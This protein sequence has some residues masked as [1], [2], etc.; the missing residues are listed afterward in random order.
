MASNHPKKQHYVP[1]FY[2]RNFGKGKKHKLYVFDKQNNKVFSA[3]PNNVLYE[4]QFYDFKMKYQNYDCI[5]SIEETLSK[6]ECDTKPILDKM[7]KEDGISFISHQEQII[8]SKFIMAQL[9]RTKNLKITYDLMPTLL[10]ENL[11]KRGLVTNDFDLGSSNYDFISFVLKMINQEYDI[12]LHKKWIWGVN[13]TKVK[14]YTSD[15]PVVY[16]QEFE[17]PLSKIF[18]PNGIGC[19]GVN[20]YLPITPKRV[21]MLFCPDWAAQITKDLRECKEMLRYCSLNGLFNADIA[22]RISVYR[23]LYSSFIDDKPY[24]LEANFISNI[25]TLEVINA[26]RYIV[27]IED[28]FGFAKQIIKSDSEFKHGARPEIS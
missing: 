13:D 4:N 7:L 12:L 19:R 23:N 22:K 14:L 9:V 20:I 17:K 15:V 11:V 5:F 1:Q 18:N 16:R 6:L 25:N 10:K 24:N 28:D 21:L 8:L 26:E 27:S 3:Q 2:L